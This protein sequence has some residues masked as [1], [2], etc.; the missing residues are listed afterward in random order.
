MDQLYM[1]QPKLIE[2]NQAAI[3]ESFTYIFRIRI[4]YW[5][6]QWQALTKTRKICP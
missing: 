5:H 4:V 3:F 1:L 2:E 6:V